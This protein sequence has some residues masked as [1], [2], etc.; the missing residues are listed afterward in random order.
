MESLQKELCP[1]F[2][3]PS[4]PGEDQGPLRHHSASVFISQWRE[5][6]LKKSRLPAC[7]WELRP[8]SP[9]L[10]TLESDYQ[11]LT[12]SYVPGAGDRCR[13]VT[14]PCSSCVLHREIRLFTRGRM[15]SGPTRWRMPAIAADREAEAGGELLKVSLGAH[16]KILSQNNNET[17]PVRWLDTLRG[18]PPSLTA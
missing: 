18:L 10:R 3:L 8:S 4:S 9:C 13:T 12:C 16:S 15:S 7:Q 17:G 1:G 14:T 2:L 6:A 5:Q 11:C